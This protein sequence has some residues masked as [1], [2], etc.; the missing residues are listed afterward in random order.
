METVPYGFSI[1]PYWSLAVVAAIAVVG[2]VLLRGAYRWAGTGLAS[3]PR[4]LSRWLRTVVLVLLVL[5]LL[6]PSAVLRQVLKEQGQILVLVDTSASMD[7]ADEPGGRTRAQSLAGAFSEARG[8]YDRLRSLY[9][10]KP[11]EFAEDLRIVQEFGFSAEGGR[12]ALGDALTRALRGRLPTRL[13][14]VVVATDGA[15]NT[16]ASPE[17]VA[18]AYRKLGVPLYV[19][20]CGREQVG[21]ESRDLVLQNLAAP[22]AVFVRNVAAITASVALL[23]VAHQP[24]TVRLLIDEEEVDRRTVATRAQQEVATVRFRYVPTSEGYRKVTVEATPLPGERTTGNN[25]ASAYLNVLSGQLSVL[26]L[27]GAVRWEFKFL[28]R[29]LEE[30]REVDLAA[31][32]VLAPAGQDRASVLRAEEDWDRFDV[33]ILGDVPGDRFTASQLE[34]LAE[35]VTEGTGLVCLAGYQTYGAAFFN[36]PLQPVFPFYLEPFPLQREDT[37]RVRP[38]AGAV[39]HPAV[40]LS[41]GDADNSEV[42]AALPEVVGG[43][44]AGRLKPAATVLLEDEAGKPVLVV[45]PYGRGR[46]VT[47]LADTTWRWA[48][49]GDSGRELHRRF[50]RQ[51]VLWA[52]GRED[53]RRDNL[54]IELAQSRYFPKEPVT[55]AFHLESVGGEPISDATIVATVS[56]QPDGRPQELRLYRTGDHWEAL[57]NPQEEAD[58]VIQARAYRGDPDAIE[59]ELVDEASARFLVER[60]NLELADPLAHVGLL[61]QMAEM[62]GGRLLRPDKL[63]SL[64]EELAERDQHVELERVSRRDLWNHPLLLLLIVGLLTGDWVLRKRAGLV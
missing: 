10:V 31:R 17:D 59:A 22:K 50:W 63:G 21:P 61:S 51:L 7:V 40:K 60:T 1:D 35:V 64:L 52:A 41:K 13:A 58:Y 6:R 20:A 62:T 36:T 12:T 2:L 25:R 33:V 43:V 28:R 29:A 14:A 45:Q 37:Y 38:T 27:E 34:G 44:G 30:A 3:R 32:I 49:A 57:L 54:W 42:W 47:L 48:V 11:Y 23:G 18:Q 5:C 8:P 4:R 56:A 9:Q 24:V 46:V 55:P 15:S 16:G 53:V 19:V 39:T 26:Y